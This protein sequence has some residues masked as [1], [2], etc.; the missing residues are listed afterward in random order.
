[1]IGKVMRCWF[2][3]V[4]MLVLCPALAMA[5]T[6]YTKWAVVTD[7]Q[8]GATGD[9][10]TDD[11]AAIQK[12]IDTGLPVYFPHGDS[13]GYKYIVK[14]QL[15]LSTKGQILSGHAAYGGSR[16]WIETSGDNDFNNSATG[17]F[18]L[19]ASA[20]DVTFRDLWIEFNQP[21]SATR[22]DYTQPPAIYAQNVTGLTVMNCRINAAW[23]GIDMRGNTSG[24]WIKNVESFCYDI[25]YWIDG[26]EGVVNFEGVHSGLFSPFTNTQHNY[27][28]IPFHYT[29]D[30]DP[31]LSTSIKVGGVSAGGMVH[32]SDSIF[33]SAY[34]LVMS[35]DPNPSDDIYPRV[36]I[37]N[38]WSE[39][40]SGILQLSGELYIESMV[41]GTDD[42]SWYT[43]DDPTD[44]CIGVSGGYLL[45]QKG[46]TAVLRNVYLMSGSDCAEAFSIYG[47]CTITNSYLHR[48]GAADEYAGRYRI[49]V[50]NGGSLVIGDTIL[51]NSGALHYGNPWILVDNGGLIQ[52]VG[53][54]YIEG[55]T[56][57]IAA[58]GKHI[59]V[60][61]VFGNSG[62]PTTDYDRPVIPSSRP[63][64]IFENNIYYGGAL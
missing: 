43:P 53:C 5:A 22:S 32:V 4:S 23:Q 58:D 36:T 41:M 49:H 1:M 55:K 7:A 59:V 33:F 35:S 46:G 12:A 57:T 21:N 51:D 15:N 52:Q 54:R 14:N 8:F 39:R 2:I 63:N 44:I 60:G 6:A 24:A 19:S 29:D 3:A 27:G 31:E 42:A 16:I 50:Y 10:V 26:L 20:T 62:G 30:V 25:T 64:M 38:G 13:P 18:V 9:G 37:K 28:F 47:Q 56:L 11:T 48:N 40:G 45:R 17:V 61:N 34:D